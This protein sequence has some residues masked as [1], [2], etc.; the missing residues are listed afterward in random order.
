MDQDILDIR[1]LTP[2]AVYP[3]TANGVTDQPQPRSRFHRLLLLRVACEDDLRSVALGELQ[4][5]MRLAGR[6]HPRFVDDNDSVSID[7]DAAPRGEA[8]QLVDAERPCIDIVAERHRR[9]PGHGGGDNALSVFAVEIGDGPNV[10]VLPEPAAPSMIATR[11]PDEVTARI[12]AICSS[13]SE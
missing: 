13:L 3:D 2:D 8:Q 12:A 4:N 11:P 1:P 5:M 6:Q 9:A 7:I 10:V